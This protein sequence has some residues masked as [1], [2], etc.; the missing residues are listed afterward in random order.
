MEL[1]E[2][3]K[4]IS[5]GLESLKELQLSDLKEGLI[6]LLK[7]LKSDKYSLVMVEDISRGKV[8]MRTYIPRRH[9]YRLSV[10]DYGITWYLEDSYEQKL[11]FYK[12][13]RGKLSS[14][15]AS[16]M[17][18]N[19]EPVLFVSKDK[20]NLIEKVVRVVS[21]RTYE[22]FASQRD[23]ALFTLE[24]Q[25]NFKFEDKKFPD[26][27]TMHQVELRDYSHKWFFIWM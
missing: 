8:S 18:R 10:K 13:H 25:V 20:N 23:N 3:F 11:Q 14:N 17:M 7:E 19:R 15:T 22:E 9:N 24:E 27:V 6:Y 12:H 2:Q 16:K 1:M 4:E 21:C 26:T 5:F